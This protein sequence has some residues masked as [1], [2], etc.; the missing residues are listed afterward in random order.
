M[1]RLLIRWSMVVAL[2]CGLSACGG[3]GGEIDGPVDA[4]TNDDAGDNDTD[5]SQNTDNTN[6]EEEL[7]DP[8]DCDPD[9]GGSVY[10]YVDVDYEGEDS[11][12]SCERPR[13]SLNRAVAQARQ[14]DSKAVILGGESTFYG[15][16]ML[17]EGLSLLGG[18]DGAPEW[19]RNTDKVPRVLAD[20]DQIDDD[21]MEAGDDLLLAPVRVIDSEQPT[22]V[23]NLILEAADVDDYESGSSAAL[24]ALRSPGLQLTDVELIA[25]LGGDGTNGEPGADGPVLADGE[26]VGQRGHDGEEYSTAYHTHRCGDLFG[27]EDTSLAADV[28]STADGGINPH[29]PDDDTAGGYGARGDERDLD[30]DSWEAGHLPGGDAAAGLCEDPFGDTDNAL[31]DSDNGCG[32]RLFED[33]I[34]EFYDEVP[35][36]NQHGRDGLAYDERA[37]DGA[38]GKIQG[39]FRDDRWVLKGHGEDG[40]D[41]GG[42]RGGGGGASGTS[43]SAYLGPCH[44]G[45]GGGGGGAGGCG[46][47]G[48]VGATGG[49][50]SVGLIAEDSAMMRLD[51]VE[52]TTADAG[53]GGQGDEPG[54]QGQPGAE[55]GS[56]GERTWGVED[57]ERGTYGGD[58]NRGQD[59]GYSGDGAGGSSIGI[60][61]P[62]EDTSLVLDGELD[63]DTGEPGQSHGEYGPQG[64][65][66]DQQGCQLFPSDPE[67]LEDFFPTL[68]NCPDDLDCQ[69]QQETIA[70]DCPSRP[71]QQLVGCQYEECVYAPIASGDAFCTE[72]ID[73]DCDDDSVRYCVEGDDDCPEAFCDPAPETTDGGE[74]EYTD[75]VV[76]R[77]V[78]DCGTCDLGHLTCTEGEFTCSD[79]EVGGINSEFAECDSTQSGTTY[80]FVD[81][82]YDGAQT[83]DGSRQAPYSSLNEG[84]EEAQRR[85]NPVLI[86]G[87]ESTFEETIELRNA[88]SVAGG[89]EHYPTFYPEPNNRPTISVG[90]GQSDGGTVVGLDAEDITVS[91]QLQ[92]LHVEIADMT[93]H[94]GVSTT[95]LMA[96]NAPGLHLMDVILEAG[97]GGASSADGGWSIG[98]QAVGSSTLQLEDVTV[99]ASDGGDGASGEGGSSVALYCPASDTTIEADMLDLNHG[100]AGSGDT[101]DG[102]QR[103]NLDCNIDYQ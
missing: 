14:L 77:H 73:G 2:C 30:A 6:T 67:E 87:G 72:C 61:C 75:Q 43:D 63:I 10:V 46:G 57:V 59:G 29:C 26:G 17:Q 65:S 97:D 81:A 55:G 91:T 45:S 71:C 7:A 51:G 85:D 101:A 13:T 15:S 24:V 60:Y 53:E 80:L 52:I 49:G 56:P 21:I 35:Y 83:E 23:E 18:F 69:C 27:D 44:L 84:L 37:E 79:L 34:S 86:I 38:H 39:A 58:G 33:F 70:V 32:G 1:L 103:E 66:G 40:A 62:S 78:Y 92:N 16:V 20:T 76:N 94:D 88:R 5:A 74:T 36:D 11:D 12:G 89:F 31:Y 4:G 102:L 22:R 42:G 99:T 95:A 8:E 19:S 50:W 47:Q 41:G 54:G 3:E 93:S 28:P 82:T 100:T 25:G 98:V 90:A 68:Y 96:N 64:I 9:L 48:G